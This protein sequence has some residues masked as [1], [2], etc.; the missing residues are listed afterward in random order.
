MASTLER[1][2]R[3]STG[4][5]PGSERPCLKGMRRVVGQDTRRP[6]L[7]SLNV[8]RYLPHTG[9]SLPHDQELRVF[10]TVYLPMVAVWVI[11]KHMS[12]TGAN[13]FPSLSVSH[14][15]TFLLVENYLV[16]I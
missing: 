16:R 14:M 15:G 8:H 1:R 13:C 12:F 2:Q 9:M 6:P 3:G 11:L 7:D 5:T 10:P 4:A